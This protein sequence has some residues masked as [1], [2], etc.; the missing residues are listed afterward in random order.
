MLVGALKFSAGILTT[1]DYVILHPVIVRRCAKLVPIQFVLKT[2]PYF[3]F[4]TYESSIQKNM[5][6]KDE[7]SDKLYG[8]KIFESYWGGVFDTNL[9]FLGWSL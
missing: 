5:S 6:T 1:I 2:P 4:S 3:K 7:F 8:Y 9:F